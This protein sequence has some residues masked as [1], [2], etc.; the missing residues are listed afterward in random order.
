MK[1][2]KNTLGAAMLIAAPITTLTA[3]ITGVVCYAP[4]FPLGIITSVLLAVYGAILAGIE[5][6]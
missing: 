4:L 3:V 5:N 6:N 2:L 1:A